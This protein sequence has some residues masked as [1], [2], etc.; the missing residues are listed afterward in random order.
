MSRM[1]DKLSAKLA[2]NYELKGC[3]AIGR[4]FNGAGM[5]LVLAVYSDDKLV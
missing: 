3:H 2:W 1:Y 5:G 4:K